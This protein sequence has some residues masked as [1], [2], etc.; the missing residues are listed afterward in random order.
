MLYDISV[1]TW[2]DGGRA[3]LFARG[4]RFL[5][6]AAGPTLYFSCRRR[7]M[8]P[9]AALFQSRRLLI[10]RA[11]YRAKGHFLEP[12]APRETQQI[13]RRNSSRGVTPS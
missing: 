13:T 7:D 6:R 5:T 2:L 3:R 11:F 9:R 12:P 10:S 1:R 4:A 8:I